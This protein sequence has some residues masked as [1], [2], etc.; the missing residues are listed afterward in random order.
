MRFL[1]VGSVC[2]TRVPSTF[3]TVQHA[4]RDTG[5]RP[6]NVDEIR[7][8]KSSGSRKIKTIQCDRVYVCD[9]HDITRELLTYGRSVSAIGSAARHVGPVLLEIASHQGVES[10]KANAKR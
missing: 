1:F 7:Q 6:E 9:K 8:T 10:V 2:F 5:E 3:F 4:G